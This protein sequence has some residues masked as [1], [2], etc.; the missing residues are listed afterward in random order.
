MTPASSDSSGPSDHDPLLDLPPGLHPKLREYIEPFQ[1]E[2]R[3]A[4]LNYGVGTLAF[5]SFMA[6]LAGGADKPLNPVLGAATTTTTLPPP[7]PSRVPGLNE[8]HFA[9]SPPGAARLPNSTRHFCGMHAAT[10]DQ[11]AKGLMNR[12]DLANYDAMVFTFPS[13]VKTAFHMRNT[14]IPLTVAFFDAEG[15]F[16][17]AADMKP[18]R[19]R[20]CP[21]YP[22]P[23]GTLYR[24]AIEVK[25]GDLG[26]LGAGPGSTLTAGGGC[27]PT[28]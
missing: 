28:S 2:P 16:V 12:N 9:V 8:I 23:G 11:M 24:T 10:P 17:G 19:V 13:D 20:K 18:C 6:F 14:R 5:L 4:W 26:R 27:L 1:T 22:P 21:E 3:R 7:K 15:N 25:E